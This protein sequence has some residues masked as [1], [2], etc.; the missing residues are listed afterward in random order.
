MIKAEVGHYEKVRQEVKLASGDYI[1]LKAYEPAM[2]HLLDTYIRAE[3]S[4]TLSAF[5][6][7]TL[8][9]LVVE[10]G[11][12][13]I[14]SLPGGIRGNHDAVAETIENNVRRIIIDE[15]AV[16]PKYYEKM[17]E[18]LDALIT[19]RKQEAIDYKAYLE[20][21]VALTKRVSGPDSERYPPAIN[22]PA[23]RALYDNLKDV[24]G[25]EALIQTPNW[26]ADPTADVAEAATQAVDDAV[27]KI[28]KADWRGNKF[29]EQEV[30]L[31][32]KKVLQDDA[33]VAKVFEIVKAQHA[34]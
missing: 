8:V 5:D 31:A 32:I 9:Q 23:R 14:D 25:L 4:E 18:L 30:R 26:V 7:M 15:M 13:A 6:D 10:R 12:A 16:N 27:R 11:E 29:K 34:Y 21:I 19:Q 3:E 22:S 17:S 2:R 24:P 20:K 33:L 28:K 1:D